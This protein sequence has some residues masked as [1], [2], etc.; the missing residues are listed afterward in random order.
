MET[1]QKWKK[2]N[3]NIL[4]NALCLQV[5]EVLSIDTDPTWTDRQESEKKNRTV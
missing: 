2:E 5:T 4:I 1:Q 3:L